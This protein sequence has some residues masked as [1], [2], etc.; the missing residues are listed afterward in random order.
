M[1]DFQLLIIGAGPGGYTA[2]L[3][4]A[5]LGL[6]TAVVEARE[7]GGTCVNRGCVPTKT[8]LHSSEVFRAARDGAAIGVHAPDISINMEEIF[9]HKASVSET[10]SK[11]VE[12]LFKSAKVPL[13]RGTAKITAPHTVTVTDADGNV[14]QY[15]AD[16]ILIATGSVPAR[17]PIPGLDLP[18]VMTSDELLAGT[19][20]LYRSIVIIG[21]GVIGVEFATF[22]ADLGCDVTLIEGLA[23][24]LPTLDR[25]L[26]QNLALILKKAGVKVFTGAMVDSVEPCTASDDAPEGDFAVNFTVKGA[27]QRVS[28]EAV[29][30]AI[31]R[32][33]YH[34]DLFAPEL[35]P[36]LNKRSIAVNDDYETSIPGIYAIGD[37]SSRIQLAH[38]AA[39]Q[40]TDCV[41]RIAAKLSPDGAAAAVPPVGRNI[42][43]SC[44]YSRPEIAVVGMTDAE[45]KEAS[46]PVK[47]GKCVMGANAR[48]LICNP[49][50]SFMKVVANAET[51]E[52]IGAQLMCPNATD[53]ISGIAEGMAN[54]LTA[55]QL[56]AAMR[57]HPTF[58][59]ALSDALQDLCEKLA[60]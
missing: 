50:R 18:G 15:T 49:G 59:E 20:H 37:V 24:L 57:P 26:G 46:I 2:A 47:V 3:R 42:V 8:L 52:V 11:G 14:T 36:E 48:T 22:Y 29:L 56:L 51:G 28:A 35:L 33:P 39:A 7:P 6:R 19:D 44:I 25:E 5:K 10:L 32:R 4:A 38:V 23:H 17:P 40:G 31:G 34:D 53:M 9:A 1:N 58:E 45:A 41:N 16:N 21:G 12:G 13:V 27:P 60:R 54:H 30:C 55:A 43:P